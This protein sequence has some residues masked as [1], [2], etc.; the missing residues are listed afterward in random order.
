V[1]ETTANLSGKTILITGAA[2]DIGKALSLYFA[3]L[4]AVILLLDHDARG[5]NAVYDE[6]LELGAPTPTIIDVDLAKLEAPIA[7]SINNNV[8]KEFGHLDALIHT[9]NWTF[10]LAPLAVY[11]EQFWQK[12][13]NNML[14]APYLLTQQLLPALNAAPNARVVFS[15]LPCGEQAKPFWGP[16]GA[17]YAGLHSL[18]D[19][20]NDEL[21]S[22]AT[23][24]QT[25]NT[26]NVLTQVRLKHYPA[27]IQ[28]NLTLANDSELMNRYLQAVL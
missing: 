3:S 4:G 28:T 25:L 12:A 11:E 5:L 18:C 20:W 14:F 10:P 13:M 23:R 26:G 19:T 16:Y 2:F 7:V 8:L 21:Q 6:L 27:E 9:A 1:P 15:I 17:A 22:K 24:F